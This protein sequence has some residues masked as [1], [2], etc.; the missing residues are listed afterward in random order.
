MV[1]GEDLVLEAGQGENLL[2][3]GQVPVLDGWLAQLCGGGNKDIPRSRVEAHEVH[4]V[5]MAGELQE[6][7]GGVLGEPALGNLPHANVAVVTSSRNHARVKGVEHKVEN[8]ARVDEGRELRGLP[9]HVLDGDN[10]NLATGLVE[11]HS[12]KL[13]TNRE[14][15]ALSGHL[16]AEVLEVIVVGG[17]VERLAGDV[18]V[19]GLAHAGEL[20]LDVLHCNYFCL[21]WFRLL[22]LRGG[23]GGVKAH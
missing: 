17:R 20:V 23:G 2:S 9:A 5:S 15:I 18:T 14:G 11:G 6:H 8:L 16:E 10:A 12:E 22:R 7:L 3:G 19:A 4:P 21:G 1:E 13:R